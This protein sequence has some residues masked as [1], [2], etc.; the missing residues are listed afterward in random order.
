MKLSIE[1]AIDLCYRGRSNMVKAAQAADVD[2]EV[3]KRLLAE[4]VS[5]KVVEL[6]QQ[7]IIPLSFS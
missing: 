7:L 1:E 4:K 3:L 5:G 6:E 2:V